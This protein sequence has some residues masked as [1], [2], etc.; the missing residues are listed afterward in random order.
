MID[1]V[2]T[3]PLHRVLV[4]YIPTGPGADAQAFGADLAGA[5]DA[6][7][8][9]ASVVSAVRIE[10]LGAHTGPAVVH[11]GERDRAAS[12]LA[13]AAAELEDRSGLGP[14]EHRLEAA[15]SAA[16]GLHDLAASEEADL[17]VVGPS[18][19]GRVGR[20]LL[21]SIGTRLLS[22]APCAIAVADH[23]Y[24]S[25]RAHRIA[26]IGVA[27]DGAPESRLALHTA[28]ALAARIGASLRVVMVVE[29]PSAVP[30]RWVELPGLDGQAEIERTDAIERLERSL[31][32]VL[33][34]AVSEL[35]AGVD[36]AQSTL[37]EPHPVEAITEL[38]GNVDLLVLGSRG[39]GPVRRTLLG[40]VSAP[41]LRR[42][43][44][45]VLVTPRTEP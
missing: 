42:A 15:H 33:A 17:V 35:S 38:A 36:V 19:R 27:F 45:P 37:L 9:L 41:V 20:R 39:Y 4:G 24:A 29:P 32:C 23:G 43:T 10:N 25:R 34:D 14:V 1:M 3:A 5:C 16:R 22:G 6:Q 8:L 7:L 40:G 44:C 21:G 26:T 18:H 11:G 12:A 30:G 2:G 28:H 31:G 13:E